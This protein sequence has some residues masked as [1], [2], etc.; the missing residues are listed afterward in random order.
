MLSPNMR[1]NTSMSGLTTSIQHGIGGPSQ[2]IEARRKKN[3]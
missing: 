1:K 2:G 3:A